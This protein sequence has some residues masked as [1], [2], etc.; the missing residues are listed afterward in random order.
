MKKTV[1]TSL[2][3]TAI[4][5]SGIYAAQPLMDD[6]I[7]AL[8]PVDVNDESPAFTAWVSKEK[9]I[10]RKSHPCEQKCSNSVIL[11]A[12]VSYFR[13]F[14]KTLRK[15]FHNGGVDY[16]LEVSAPV[17][18]GL[19][20][21]G[22]VDYFS[23]HGKM[24]HFDAST[25]ITIVPLTLGL[26]YIYSVNQYFG[27]YGGAGFKYFFVKAINR[28]TV[29]NRTIHRNGLGGV[30]ELGTLFCITHHLI[31]DVF[32]SASFKNFHGPKHHSTNVRPE[33][34]QVGGWN[35]GAGIG[36]KF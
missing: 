11:E 13:P 29:L 26:K 33:N 25:R 17:W 14:S 8:V 28:S 15:M 36:Y 32:G 23:R 4:L 35:V 24:I 18:K 31:L 12:R 7:T 10:Q 6:K 16:A 9:N 5:Q 30:L 2:F 34:L 21:W 22:A 20:I 19:N 27:L 3:C 1:L